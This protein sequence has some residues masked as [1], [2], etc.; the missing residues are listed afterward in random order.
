[1]CLLRQEND[2]LIVLLQEGRMPRLW[3]VSEV[4]GERGN[5]LPATASLKHDVVQ[6]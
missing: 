5:G 6:E 2:R 3:S 4:L 1:M